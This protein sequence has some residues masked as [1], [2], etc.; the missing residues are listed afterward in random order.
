LSKGMKCKDI[1]TFT[2]IQIPLPR[3]FLPSSRIRSKEGMQEVNFKFG[4]NLFEE[5][6]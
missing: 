4:D 2:W 6:R 3:M 1:V 5:V